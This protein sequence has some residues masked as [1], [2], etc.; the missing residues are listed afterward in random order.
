M[1][2]KKICIKRHTLA[3]GLRVVHSYDGS[4]V[5]AAVNILYNVGSRD[6]SRRLT[7]MAHLFEHL[8]FGGSAHVPDFDAE[9][10]AAGGRSNAWTSTDFT[11]FYDVVPA[12]NISTAFH[13]E[14][15]RMLSLDFNPRSLEVQRSVVIEE[16]KQTC[17]NRPYGDISH[18]IRNLA[19]AENHP[20]SWP[21]IGLEPEHIAKVT[22]DDVREWFY[23]HYAPNN[24]ILAITGNV[25]FE[26]TVELAETWFG[27]IPRR[28]IA[29]R[30]LPDEEFPKEN[31]TETVYRHVPQPHIV[32]AF[33]MAAY[34]E[35]EYFTADTITD[36][37]AVG[38]SSRLM[39]NLVFGPV[40]GL[41]AQADASIIGSEQPG[42]L[43]L[44]A[45][46]ASDKD[47]DIGRAT[48]M[49]LGQA[50][51]LASPGNVSDHE[52]QRC[53]NKFESTFRF[54]NAGY[55]ARATNLAQA[56]MHGEDLNR[57]VTDRRILTPDDI[58]A[59][60]DE[61]F[62]RRPFV[63]LHYRPVKS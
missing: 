18:L 28:E 23:A 39:R 20:Y 22:M 53:L 63:T 17:L 29:E 8:M 32:M 36:I 33:P 27:D 62:N 6:E 42:L 38:R 41:F 35:K 5:M 9:L 21:T 15:D 47:E 14:S 16:F 31:I 24:A 48:E 30:R 40:P 7:G 10:E 13:L 56:E 19:Y 61:L 25:D 44:S 45:R 57:T 55:L 26:K 58:A 4:T 3:N 1:S 46:L 34:G 37:L 50:R 52:L 51:Q 54:S 60:A 59:T 11:N 12:Q 43:L 49:L 2:L